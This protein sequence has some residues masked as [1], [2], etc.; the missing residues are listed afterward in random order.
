MELGANTYRSHGLFTSYEKT[1]VLH[2]HSKKLL[3]G[4]TEESERDLEDELGNM[5]G[6]NKHLITLLDDKSSH[7]SRYI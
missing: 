2:E 4:C 5:D 6:F 1:H 7:I 3:E